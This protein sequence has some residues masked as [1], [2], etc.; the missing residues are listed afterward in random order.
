MS[1]S[2]PLPGLKQRCLEYVVT[3]HMRVFGFSYERF[4]IYTLMTLR[5]SKIQNFGGSSKLCVF[6]DKD[7]SRWCCLNV[8]WS[9]GST[10]QRCRVGLRL[11]ATSI[12]IGTWF[13]I[14]LL[15]W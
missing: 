10:C 3:L 7:G 1:W 2:D 13:I 15:R 6:A 11:K 14:P 5:E 4:V 12:G 9:S 8:V